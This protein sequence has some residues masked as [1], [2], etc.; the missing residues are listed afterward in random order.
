LGFENVKTFLKVVLLLIV[1]VIAIKLLPLIFVLACLFVG[2]LVGLFALGMSAIVAMIGS[3]FV[4]LAVTSPIWVPV[5]AI[6]GL[7][8]LANR[9][10]RRS[11][12]IVA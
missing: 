2:A 3:A 6:V 1:A 12:G 5:L 10:N 9:S 11:G 8:A 4:V 7:I